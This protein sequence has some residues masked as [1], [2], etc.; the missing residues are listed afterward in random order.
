M[1]YI[2][3]V[4]EESRQNFGRTYKIDCAFCIFLMQNSASTSHRNEFF[5]AN[6]KLSIQ[7]ITGLLFFTL[8][9]AIWQYDVKSIDT[10]NEQ[11]FE[12]RTF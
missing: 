6:Q 8:F 10:S 12:Q 7:K 9:Y 5:S 2:P 4:P 11:D 1:S 3:G